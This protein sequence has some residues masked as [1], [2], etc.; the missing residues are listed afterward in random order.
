MGLMTHPTLGSRVAGI[1]MDPAGVDSGQFGRACGTG[2]Q[3]VQWGGMPKPQR[4]K[5]WHS[6]GTLLKDRA[7]AV[8]IRY[9]RL[10][11]AD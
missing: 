7:L 2:F 10:R 9:R 6:Q 3:P 8:A 4:P 1:V 5:G 11:N